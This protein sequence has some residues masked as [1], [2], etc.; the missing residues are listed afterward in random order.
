MLQRAAKAFSVTSEK[1]D[2]VQKTIKF[3]LQGL[4]GTPIDNLKSLGANGQMLARETLAVVDNASHIAS[5]H[6]LEFMDAVR[7]AFGASWYIKPEA[8]R[9]LGLSAGENIAEKV[10]AGKTLSPKET[11]IWDAWTNIESK[12]TEQAQ[13]HGVL[14]VERVGSV[15]GK[16][17]LNERVHWSD[18]EFD[19]SGIVKT[20]RNAGKENEALEV[21]SDNGKKY[22]LTEGTIIRHRQLVEHGKYWPRVLKYDVWESIL[23][24]EGK[25]MH[26]A[27]EH[28]K[29]LGVANN[30]TEARALILNTYGAGYETVDLTNPLLSRLV[31]GRVGDLLPSEMYNR[32]MVEIANYHIS[33]SALN[34]AA[35]K[36]W[37]GGME[38]FAAAVENAGI[39]GRDAEIA[40]RQL[41]DPESLSERHAN[42]LAFLEGT[43]QAI[44]KLSH[45][46]TAAIQLG[47][48]S[49]VIGHLGFLNVAKAASVL[50]KDMLSARTLIRTIREAGVLD[51]QYLSLLGFGDIR[52]F[53]RSVGTA[54]VFLMKNF[55]AVG[56]YIAAVA[57]VEAAQKA[58]KKLVLLPDGTFKKNTAFRL[59]YDQMNF[60]ISDLKEM[61]NTK[62]LNQAQV[63][64]AMSGGVSLNVRTRNVDL[65][66]WMRTPL[67]KIFMRLKTF[68]Y[69]Q[70][71]IFN[72]AIKEARAGNFVPIL[73]MLGTAV[74]VGDG[75]VQAKDHLREA[76]G[77]ERKYPESVFAAAKKAWDAL[78]EGSFDSNEKIND[79][80]ALALRNV[81]DAGTFGAYELIYQSLHPKEATF[82]EPLL[83]VSV[84][85]GKNF[86]LA[87]SDIWLAIL[88]ASKNEAEL[89]DVLHSIGISLSEKEVRLA[90]NFYALRAQAK[91]EVYR[92][93]QK[94]R[95]RKIKAATNS[96]P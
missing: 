23:R 53:A 25:A 27:A 82:Y 65:P 1:L 41:F 16:K 18:G 50:A 46:Q 56:R 68:H 76:L 8:R 79:T 31:R 38:R 73:R 43:Y 62:K 60:E 84:S 92:A 81:I 63:I 39:V 93:Q 6:S 15:N 94:E 74:V 61:L 21:V 71:R 30:P 80:L 52:G 14:V 47:V 5:I 12:L 70:A 85:T 96:S 3:G 55:D 86:A 37:G 42:K 13:R 19:R 58:I 64:R 51:Q 26:L 89:F 49:N 87:T 83:P 67:G 54:A 91:G 4:I 17:F 32:N 9:A 77:M 57:G 35:A 69:G 78:S 33:S 7:K 36:K 90:R 29:K 40:L 10:Q 2:S 75:I 45:P 11:I 28:L 20:V 66:V 34:V 95:A 48:I 22:L 24:G 44:T 72:S 59:L 88:H